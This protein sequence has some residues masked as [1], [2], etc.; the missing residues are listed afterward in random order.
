MTRFAREHLIGLC[1][2]QCK[3]Q[4]CES[5][6]IFGKFMTKLINLLLQAYFKSSEFVHNCYLDDI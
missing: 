1:V 5:R 4:N 2:G 6:S 3:N